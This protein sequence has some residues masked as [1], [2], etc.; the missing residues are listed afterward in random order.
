M[1]ILLLA[2]QLV[3]CGAAKIPVKEPAK[4]SVADLK[5]F[6]AVA[7]EYLEY[8]QKKL[9]DR[10]AGTS[11][12]KTAYKYLKKELLK[13]GYLEEDIETQEFTMQGGLPSR[14]LVLKK[15]GAS[16]K[17]ILIGAH[18]DSVGTHGVDDN[19]SGVVAV[20]ECA[21][22]AFKIETPYSY[23]F[24]FFGAEETG[25][26]GSGYYAANMTKEEKKNTL[27]IINIDSILAGD[28]QYLYGGRVADSGKVTG[29]IPLQ[30]VEQLAKDCQ[31]NMQRNVGLNPDYPTPITGD[32]SD[33]VPFKE[34][35]ISYVYLEATNWD[36]PPYDGMAETKNLG[37]IMHTSNDDLEVINKEFP[38][39]AKKTLADFSKLLS[40]VIEYSEFE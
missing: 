1:I 26:E 10:K 27:F 16:T 29:Y 11:Q 24:I 30:K 23:R 33:H 25:L 4:K 17:E 13:M 18:Y 19:G 35:G 28:F 40:A 38:G 8:F 12:E 7:Y 34:I 20:L 9:P 22:R 31:L 14:N 15:K 21:K 39:R 6:G 37:E 32:W 2:A 3:G 5:V 36:L